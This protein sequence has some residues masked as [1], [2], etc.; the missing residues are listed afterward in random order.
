MRKNKL[1][2]IIS[3]EIDKI[4]DLNQQDLELVPQEVTNVLREQ[5]KRLA[6]LALGRG[7]KNK[8]RDQYRAAIKLVRDN[9]YPGLKVSMYDPKL[10]AKSIRSLQSAATENTGE[11]GRAVAS[12]MSQSMSYF[13]TEL[14]SAL[15]A[16]LQGVYEKAYISISAATRP[17]IKELRKVVSDIMKSD[18]TRKEITQVNKIIRSGS[19]ARAQNQ[20]LSIQKAVDNAGDEAVK[21]L[22]AG[23]T[24]SQQ[25]AARSAA[26][27]KAKQEFAERTIKPSSTA[28]DEITRGVF[29]M[30]RRSRKV[31]TD[32]IDN[33][34]GNKLKGAET[35]SMA[36]KLHGATA[37]YRRAP[38]VEMLSNPGKQAVLAALSVPESMFKA[39]AWKDVLLYG[40]KG[41]LNKIG[42]GGTKAKDIINLRQQAA[43]NG[44]D[45]ADTAKRFLLGLGIVSTGLSM[46]DWSSIFNA[47]KEPF[48]D[49]EGTEIVPAA[50]S[51]DAA[52]LDSAA[53]QAT[54]IAALSAEEQAELAAVIAMPK[55]PTKSTSLKF[56]KAVTDSLF[57]RISKQPKVS[58]LKGKWSVDPDEWSVTNLPVEI[59][60]ELSSAGSTINGQELVNAIVAAAE[61]LKTAKQ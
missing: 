3:E 55:L 58:G 42:I 13:G 27:K 43:L 9:A 46:T 22:P 11:M 52:G 57:K 4:L 20:K 32:K 60:T 30:E 1:D 54:E 48:V 35:A 47:L 16:K 49:S 17:D 37:A 38:G 10:H 14:P 40:P 5:K 61:K 8:V 44:L 56:T 18:L 33:I 36:R 39:A 59:K 7:A 41:A 28:A 25:R 24:K 31:L 21:S 12:R 19:G 50:D 6:Q 51:A 26:S 34:M 53:A 23:A 15:T 2:I 45:S 29:S